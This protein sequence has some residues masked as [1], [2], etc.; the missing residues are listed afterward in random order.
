MN[1]VLCGLPKCGKTTVGKLLSKFYLVDFID[2]DCLIE[3]AYFHQTGIRMT[4]REIF[5]REGEC[6][7][8][9]WEAEQIK[10][11]PGEKRSVISLG[12]GSLMN[13]ESREYVKSLGQ[14]IY[15]QSDP[16]IVWK[17]IAA[18]GVPAYLDKRNPEEEF[19]RI[20]AQ[21]TE[22]YESVATHVIETAHFTAAEVVEL[23]RRRMDG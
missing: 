10:T 9:Q 18:R 20:A 8:R 2:V 4:C 3:S 16:R 1:I 17:R 14:I 13:I 6:L 22:D 23:I 19:Y 5:L 12:G 7:F 11:L 21:R 15:L